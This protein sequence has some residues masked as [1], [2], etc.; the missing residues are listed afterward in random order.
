MSEQRLNQA[1]VG[2]ALE[3]MGGEAMPERVERERLAQS[4]VFDRLLEQPAE[5]TRGQRPMLTA[6]GKQ[7]VEKFR[8]NLTARF[9]LAGN[10]A[11]GEQERSP[12]G[13]SRAARSVS[14]ETLP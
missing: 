12:K 8:L 5:L 3:Q 4:P 7:P 11:A 9:E 6:A 14:Q 1:N 10:G 2:A 13:R